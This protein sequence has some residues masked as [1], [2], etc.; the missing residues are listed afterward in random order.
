M[1][2]S[3]A[4][5]FAASK[6]KPDHAGFDPSMSGFIFTSKFLINPNLALNNTNSRLK[7]NE[8]G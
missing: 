8:T 4:F 3:Y 7:P 2:G 6:P 5:S 1:G